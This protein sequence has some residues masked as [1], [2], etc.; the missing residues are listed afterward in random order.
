[1][2]SSPGMFPYSAVCLGRQQMR[3]STVPALFTLGNW[4]LFLRTLASCSPLCRVLQEYR[5]L[6]FW[7]TTSF[8]Y[9]PR[10]DSGYVYR[11]SIYLRES[12]L[13]DLRFIGAPW[14]THFPR[15]GGIR[16]RS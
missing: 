16:L 15:E 12:G 4:T 5:L 7:E 2:D 6:V 8:P 13:R 9:S 11:I 1:M 3:Q 14:F 10:C